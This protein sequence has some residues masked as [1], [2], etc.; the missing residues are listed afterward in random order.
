MDEIRLLAALAC[1]FVAAYLLGSLVQLGSSI[2]DRP[3]MVVTLVVAAG[4]VVVVAIV[5]TRNAHR[6]DGPYW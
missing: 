1:V 5:G 2:A 6:L 4:L 3:A